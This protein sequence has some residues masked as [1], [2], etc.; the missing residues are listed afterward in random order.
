MKTILPLTTTAF[1]AATM[2][3]TLHAE[4]TVSES[5]DYEL[6][7]Q[8]AGQ[9]NAIDGWLGSWQTSGGTD[10]AFE[11][12]VEG[13]TFGDLVVAGNASQRSVRS[14]L[15][16]MSRE[17]SLEAQTALTADDSTMWFSVLMTPT[18]GN[19]FAVNSY[20][21][22]IFGDA[23]LSSGSGVSAAPIA[24]GGN[25]VGVSFAGTGLPA[26]DPGR[27]LFENMRIQGVT[28]AGGVLT[29]EGATVVGADTSLV[30]GS[31]DWAE[32]GTDDT[33]NLYLFTDLTTALPDPFVT[34]LVDLDQ[35]TFNVVSIGDGQT[36]IFDEIRF[37]LSLTDVLG[38]LPSPQGLEIV[39]LSYDDT[40]E[41]GNI[42]LS[43]TFTSEV[44]KTYIA[45]GAYNLDL[46]LTESF[47][48]NDAIVGEEGTTTFM[49]DFDQLALSKTSPRFFVAISE[50]A[51]VPE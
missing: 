17:I 48:L 9:G 3:S 40:T 10:Q 14:G 34:M 8:V 13:Q 44:G 51:P 29:Q 12:V 2:I 6:G 33:L 7:T 18:G 21:T 22:L 23:S 38:D 36:S 45:Y 4:P 19:G 28:Y 32:N 5:F 1:V 37:G 50:N 42:L 15:Q 20:G 11:T 35:S 39:D 43:V 26:G 27:G 41:P 16:A 31:V 46:P 30:V 49:V 25:A 24:A 47:D